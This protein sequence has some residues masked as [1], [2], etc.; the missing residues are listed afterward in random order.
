[1]DQP[2]TQNQTTFDLAVC[3]RLQEACRDVFLHHPEVKAV[4]VAICWN[5]KLNEAEINHGLW[6]GPD[7]PVTTPDGIVGSVYQT[8][9][10]LDIQLGRGMEL[11]L[12]L[13][14]DLTGLYKDLLDAN[15]KLEKAKAQLP[16]EKAGDGSAGERI[17]ERVIRS[18]SD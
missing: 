18:F 1:M 6:V 14:S 4:S 2:T 16:A 3:N 15:E 7:G 12:K 8:L 11:A 17:A 9:R 10:L 5:G 13:Q